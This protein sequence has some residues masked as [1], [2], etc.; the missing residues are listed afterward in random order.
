MP[1]PSAESGGQPRRHGGLGSAG[2]AG[3]A[4]S[5]VLDGLRYFFEA[6]RL[7][8]PKQRH[9]VEH[10]FPLKGRKEMSTQR[11]HAT[12]PSITTHGAT[13]PVRLLQK[14]VQLLLDAG[15]RVLPHVIDASLLPVS[16]FLL[17]TRGL[18]LLFDGNLENGDSQ[19]NLGKTKRQEAVFGAISGTTCRP[20]QRLVLRMNFRSLEPNTCCVSHHTLRRRWFC[21]P[22]FVK[23]YKVSLYLGSLLRKTCFNF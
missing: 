4:S 16:P 23:S 22:R 6:L 20:P 5:W 21:W 19:V 3:R 8:S 18:D 10:L 2:A 9:I 17:R 11:D 7:V 15:E 12:A 13:Q 1:L 14:P